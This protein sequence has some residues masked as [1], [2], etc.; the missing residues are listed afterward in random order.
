MS[1]LWKSEW[2]S[3]ASGGFPSSNFASVFSSIRVP[4]AQESIAHSI[5]NHTINQ[6]ED[7]TPGKYLTTREA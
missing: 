1:R 7:I 6:F 4:I 2:N 5:G 3:N